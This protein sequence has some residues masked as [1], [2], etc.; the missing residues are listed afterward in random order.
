MRTVA[1]Q[2]NSDAMGSWLVPVGPSLIV[3]LVLGPLA[4]LLNPFVGVLAGRRFVPLIARIHH[5]GRRSGKLYMT[6]TGASVAG[7]T[8]VIPLSFGNGSS[9]GP[10]CAGRRAVRRSAGW[11]ELPRHATT[12]RRC[13]GRE[14]RCGPIIQRHQPVRIQNVGY[15][16]VP[17]SAHNQLITRDRYENTCHT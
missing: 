11:Q 4:K 16:A 12:V 15:Q 10:Q 1:A 9:L 17:V 14:T 13:A 3:R 5:V 8:I 7:N 6:P 2:P